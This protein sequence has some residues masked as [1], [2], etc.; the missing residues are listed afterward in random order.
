MDRADNSFPDVVDQFRHV[1]GEFLLDGEIVPYENG[2]VLPFA[3]IQR[4]LGR[5]SLTPKILKAHPARF[6]AFDILYQNERILMDQPLRERRAALESLCRIERPTDVSDSTPVKSLQCAGPLLLTEIAEIGTAE[7]IASAFNEARNRRNEGIILKDPDSVYSPGRRG[8]LWFKLKTHL[9]TFDC[10]VT[11]AEFG[12]GKR[13]DWLSDYTFAV[14]SDDPA[15]TPGAK[16]VNIG[17]AYSG[18]TEEEIVQLTDLFKKI[19][20]Q[21]FGRVHLV[22]P[23]VVLEIACDQIQK[24]NRH[25]SGYALR[26]PRIKRIRWD[27]RPQDADRLARIIEIYQSSPNFAYRAVDGGAPAPPPAP[28][29]TLFDF[30]HE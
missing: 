30:L 29:P 28:E 16:L 24:S 13:R 11:A 19:S 17:K 15:T 1:P 10:V 14:W 9:P 7:Q 25:A 2:Q 5:K 8:Q 3:N 4:R 21:S 18:L 6:I 22:E 20:L 23:H 27:K 12:H 26:F